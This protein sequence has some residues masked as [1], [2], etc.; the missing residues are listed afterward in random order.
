MVGDPRGRDGVAVV[1]GCPE[2]RAPLD[3]GRAGTT[4]APCGEAVRQMMLE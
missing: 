1:V 4:S 2:V 3:R